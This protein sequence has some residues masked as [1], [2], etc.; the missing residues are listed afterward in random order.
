MPDPHE[1]RVGKLGDCYTDLKDRVGNLQT[2][3]EKDEELEDERHE[4][5]RHFMRWIRGLIGRICQL[6]E[7]SIANN[8]SNLP[9]THASVSHS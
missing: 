4:D 7:S 5:I 8:S 1:R 3:Q 6:G 9:L 2:A